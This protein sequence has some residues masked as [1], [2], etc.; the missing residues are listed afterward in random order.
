M[1]QIVAYWNIYRWVGVGVT[2]V[3]IKLEMFPLINPQP[4]D[5]R[6]EPLQTAKDGIK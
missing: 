6:W 5:L 3:K 1:G 2:Q 4:Y